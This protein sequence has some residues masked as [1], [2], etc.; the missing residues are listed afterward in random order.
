MCPQETETEPF[1]QQLEGKILIL[2]AAGY[3][4]VFIAGWKVRREEAIELQATELAPA[5]HYQTGCSSISGQLYKAKPKS[6]DTGASKR[7]KIAWP[8]RPESREQEPM[9]NFFSIPVIMQG[10]GQT[11]K[12]RGAEKNWLS[13]AGLRKFRVSTFNSPSL[14]EHLLLKLLS[15]NQPT[16]G[17]G[18]SWRIYM[19]TIG[20]FLSVFI[21]L[22]HSYHPQKLWLER[23]K[24]ELLF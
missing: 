12:V 16:V 9:N 14:K 20:A 7:H 8:H 2:K 21:P 1:S 5:D 3:R 17:N 13:G 15:A 6:E 19:F 24:H 23:W 22:V 4:A 10:I 18:L 11:Q